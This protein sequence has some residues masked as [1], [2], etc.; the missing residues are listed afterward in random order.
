[1]IVNGRWIRICKEVVAC[2]KVLFACGVRA[3][4]PAEVY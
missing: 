2:F 1:M 4:N 3:G